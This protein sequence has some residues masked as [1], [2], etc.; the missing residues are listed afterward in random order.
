[1]FVCRLR[2]AKC[3][4]KAFTL[5]VLIVTFSAWTPPLTAKNLTDFNIVG[6]DP[7]SE[8]VLGGTSSASQ[9]TPVEHPSPEQM[10][11]LY[12][13]HQRYQEAIEAYRQ[14][15]RDSSA[16]WNKLGIANQQM[17]L[18]N[19]ARKSYQIALKLDSSNP[20]VLNNLGTILYTL[21][22]YRNAE[23]LYRKAIKLSP[24]APLI[25]KNLGTDMMAERKFKKGLE[26]FQTA[27]A[28]DPNV[29]ERIGYY[30]VGDPATLEL[31]GAMNY[32][33]AK[34]YAHAGMYDRA[35]ELL[36]TAIDE[37][38]ADRKKIMADEEFAGLRDMPAFQK[39]FAEQNMQ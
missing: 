8:T 25:Y 20:D 24:K 2:R 32:Y 17:L 3:I 9:G 7:E 15:P 22:Q 37:R 5:F 10:G 21:K 26:C 12:M 14:G 34:S 30:H 1:M 33:L 18:L 29:L 4:L 27:L 38:F 36:R 35:I 28:L 6:T 23:K 16:I 31:R 11:D 39:L 19:E 13:A